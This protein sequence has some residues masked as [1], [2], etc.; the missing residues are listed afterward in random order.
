[1]DFYLSLYCVSFYVLEISISGLPLLDG[2]ILVGATRSS[3]VVEDLPPPLRPVSGPIK[4]VLDVEAIGT[5]VVGVSSD[6]TDRTIYL[7]IRAAIYLGPQ[8]P[9]VSIL[10]A[11]VV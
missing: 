3:V 6:V 4:G 8:G 5:T 2:D 11:T 10:E 9:K 1:M 7:N